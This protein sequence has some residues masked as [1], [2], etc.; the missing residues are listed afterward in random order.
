MLYGRKSGNK[1]LVI[2]NFDEIEFSMS[3]NSAEKTAFHCVFEINIRLLVSYNFFSSDGT[4]ENWDVRLQK[5]RNSA[6]TE[7]SLRTRHELTK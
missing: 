7:N 2:S 6:K 4:V 5:D 1:N 3:I